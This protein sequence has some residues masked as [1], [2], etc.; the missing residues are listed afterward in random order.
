MPLGTKTI[1]SHS[2]FEDD[3]Y[4]HISGSG[5]PIWIKIYF[6]LFKHV[7]LMWINYL[8]SWSRWDNT[9][10][11][12]TK[13]SI[14]RQSTWKCLKSESIC[15]IIIFLNFEDSILGNGRHLWL[16]NW[17]KAKNKASTEMLWLLHF[18]TQHFILNVVFKSIGK[19]Q[20]IR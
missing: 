4:P 2:H 15:D 19:I 9:S 6:V 11:N 8:E 5:C 13:R 16:L 10:C 12:Y 20:I 1:L 14:I 3:S 17:V 7:S 18:K